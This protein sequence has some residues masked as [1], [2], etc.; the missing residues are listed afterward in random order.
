MS[1]RRA[2]GIALSSRAADGIWP[3]RLFRSNLIKIF[4][5]APFSTR[6]QRRLT[7]TFAMCVDG[8]DCGDETEC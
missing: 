7:V 1:S 6:V 4:T 3:K 2:R 5:L 8:L